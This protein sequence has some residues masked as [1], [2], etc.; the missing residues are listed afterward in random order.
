MARSRIGQRR[1]SKCERMQISSLMSGIF[2]EA[3]RWMERAAGTGQYDQH[4]HLPA[5]EIGLEAFLANRESEH[6]GGGVDRAD[7]ALRT[8]FSSAETGSRLDADS[9]LG[10]VVARSLLARATEI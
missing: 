4:L 10:R 5:R 6:N 3:E 8:T 7:N 2:K 1:Y 9:F